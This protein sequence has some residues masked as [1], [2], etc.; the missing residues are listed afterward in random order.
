MAETS[1]ELLDQPSKPSLFEGLLVGNN[2]STSKPQK[3]KILS[4]GNE[5]GGVLTTEVA[6]SQVLGKIKDFLGVMAKA[7]EKL[8]SD[9][10]G[11]S[12]SDFDIEVLDGNEQEYIEM[13]LLLGVADLHTPEAVT[14]AEATIG[15][16]HPSAASTSSSGSSDTE[17]D[18][19]EDDDSDNDDITTKTQEDPDS[20]NSRLHDS[21][22]DN[23]PNKR[24]KII[25][26]N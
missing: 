15:G 2:N 25:V 26:L 11:T 4:S 9:A 3:K 23:K 10:Q 6:K 1:K 19:D 8:Q 5:E 16:F 18:S 7:N 22:Q 14:A 20:E 12:R 13:D 21:K 17:D 24:P